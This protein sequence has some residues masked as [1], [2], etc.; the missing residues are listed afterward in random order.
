MNKSVK[1]LCGILLIVAIF[2]LGKL[3]GEN[4]LILTSS[5]LEAFPFISTPTPTLKK[6]FIDEKLMTQVVN[7]WRVQNGMAAFLE[8][9]EVCSMA[10]TRLQDMKTAFSHDKFY[11]RYESLP[12]TVSE[13]LSRDYTNEEELLEGWIDSPTH[14]ENLIAPYTYSCIKC[15]KTYCVQMFTNFELE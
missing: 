9:P 6:N 13:N 12:Y 1:V 14:Y 7:D 4:V 5:Q 3:I 15:N 2:V 8:Y 10:D 11:E